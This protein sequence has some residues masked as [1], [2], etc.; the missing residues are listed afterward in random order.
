MKKPTLAAALAQ[1]STPQPEQAAAPAAKAKADDGKI[2]T[3]MRIR[4][5]TIR[6]LKVL[7]VDRRCRVNDLVQEA[8]D[9]FLAL[10]NR[11]PAA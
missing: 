10:N 7:A 6:G 4:P 2:T 5:D 9:N 3:S 1:K 8:L 11:K